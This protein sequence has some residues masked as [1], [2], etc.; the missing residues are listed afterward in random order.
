MNYVVAAPAG[1]L[2]LYLIRK[3]GDRLPDK[4]TWSVN[5]GEATLHPLEDAVATM[6]GCGDDAWIEAAA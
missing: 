3:P 4:L 6:F 5:K 2:V 1:R